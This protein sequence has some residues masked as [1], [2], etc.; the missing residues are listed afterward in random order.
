MQAAASAFVGTHDFSA[1]RSVGTNVKSTVR[2]VFYFDVEKNGAIIVLRVC[3]DGFL[4]NMV[5]AMVGTVLYAAIGK[6]SPDDIP[7]IL[8]SG[9]RCLAGPTVPPHGLYMTGVWYDGAAG[10]LME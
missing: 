5:R 6:L 8:Q 4:Y 7:G 10:A 3:A 9:D 1:V 2:T